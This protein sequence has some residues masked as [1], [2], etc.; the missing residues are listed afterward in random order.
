MSARSFE[1]TGD[2]PRVARLL[3]EGGLF[4]PV[5]CAFFALFMLW[6]W[7]QGF[8]APARKLETTVRTSVVLTATGFAVAERSPGDSDASSSESAAG[9]GGQS[10][11]PDVLQSY[12]AQIT[13]K[14]DR[15]KRFPRRELQAGKRGIVTVQVQVTRSGEM[16]GLQVLAPS[17]HEGFNS[18]ALA[19]VRR[20][21]P[22]PAFPEELDRDSV[23]LRLQLRF[24][25]DN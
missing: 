19:A 20:A 24:L 18:E 9:Q 22:F 2:A 12:L 17:V 11:D 13:A 16:T 21:Q 8:A 23:T 3:L 10:G 7:A 6:L 15:A 14:V 1:S 5:F 4:L 25:P